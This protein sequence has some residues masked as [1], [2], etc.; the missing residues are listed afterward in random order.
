[1]YQKTVTRNVPKGVKW[2]SDHEIEFKRNGEKIR[3]KVNANKKMVDKTKG[4]YTKIKQQDGSYIEHYLGD[5]K[6][7][8]EELERDLLENQDLIRRNKIP[9]NSTTRENV[10]EI[11]DKFIL[12]KKKKLKADTKKKNYQRWKSITDALGWKQLSDITAPHTEQ[13]IEDWITKLQTEPKRDIQLPD[14]E[15]IDWHW[16]QSIMGIGEQPMI[17]AVQRL[18]ITPKEG[19]LAIVNTKRRRQRLFTREEA[20]RIIGNRN[21]PFS[22]KSTNHYIG[23]IRDF[24]NYLMKKGYISKPIPTPDK[25]NPE[26]DKRFIKRILTYQ[27]C[28]GLA[29]SVEEI[30]AVRGMLPAK[31]RSL[32]YR[33]AFT[34]MLRRHALSELRVKDLRVKDG[35]VQ[36]LIRKEI[37]KVGY[38]RTIP[39]HKPLHKEL[40]DHIKGKEPEDRVFADLDRAEIAAQVMHDVQAFGIPYI[41]EEGTLGLH[42]FRASGATHYVQSKIPLHQVAYIGGWRDYKYLV[43]V[44][45]KINGNDVV[46]AIQ[47]AFGDY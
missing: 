21:K 26:D 9:A 15:M 41:N 11:Y 35:S 45:I 43:R 36:V 46:G 3:R 33:F 37:D 13:A 8:A 38:E 2:I 34:T 1:M 14:V 24:S 5:V 31:L 27:Q 10:Q 18:G 22:Y 20:L 6:H 29:K 16:L 23:M 47:N 19:E 4:Y 7:E 42:A 44:Y 28:L 40:I 39:I 17:R 30:G 12:S 32:L 25:D